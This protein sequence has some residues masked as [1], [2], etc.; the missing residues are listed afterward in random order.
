METFQSF[1]NKLGRW[2][3]YKKYADGRTKI[4]SQKKTNSTIPYKNIKVK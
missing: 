2:I 1:N 4:L 3:K